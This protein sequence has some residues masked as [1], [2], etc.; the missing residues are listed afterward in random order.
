MNET[1]ILIAYF[2]VKI[3]IKIADSSFKLYLKITIKF[4][5]S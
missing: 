4:Q 2:K 1:T 5:N 3:K